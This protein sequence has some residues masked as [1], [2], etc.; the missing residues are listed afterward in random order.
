MSPLS[1]LLEASN[2]GHSNPAPMGTRWLYG[3]T[4]RMLREV[5]FGIGINQL[6]EWCEERVPEALFDGKASRNFVGSMTAGVACGYL[7]HIPHNMSAL[8]LLQPHKSYAE[9]FGGLVEDSA[10]RMPSG[11]G[12]PRSAR[13]PAAAAAAILM[14]K[15]VMIRSTQIAGSFAIINGTINLMARTWGRQVDRSSNRS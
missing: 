12:L 5:I 6:S 8:K 11:L 2:A 15:G 3:A 14:P 13:W 7:S 4:P 1:G 10:T 9:H